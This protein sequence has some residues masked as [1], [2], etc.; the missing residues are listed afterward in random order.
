MICLQNDFEIVGGVEIWET[1]FS[2]HNVNFLNNDRGWPYYFGAI[3]TFP[4]IGSE[5]GTV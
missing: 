1:R 5:V 2:F 3:H 4:A